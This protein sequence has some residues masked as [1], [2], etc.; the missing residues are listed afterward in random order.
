MAKIPEESLDQVETGLGVEQA[1]VQPADD[2]PV[3][4]LSFEERLRRKEEEKE[5]RE[6]ERKKKERER[7]EEG[8]KRRQ[9][10]KRLVE[11]QYYVDFGS[12]AVV[13]FVFFVTCLAGLLYGTSPTGLSVRAVISVAF[14]SVFVYICRRIVKHYFLPEKKKEQKEEEEEEEKE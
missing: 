7:V 3:E 13:G 10:Q 2:R 9:K 4:E 11:F 14:A 5:R 12:I 8:K 1:D 6:K